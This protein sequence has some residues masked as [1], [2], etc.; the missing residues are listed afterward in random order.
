MVGGLLLLFNCRKCYP[1]DTAAHCLCCLQVRRLGGSGRGSLPSPLPASG[2]CSLCAMCQRLL[3]PWPASSLRN[4]CC[5]MY[6]TPGACYLTVFSKEWIILPK[7]LTYLRLFSPVGIDC[8][9]P[10]FQESGRP[11]SENSWSQWSYIPEPI[12]RAFLLGVGSFL[13]LILKY[14]FEHWGLWNYHISRTV[15]WKE[16][17]C[18]FNN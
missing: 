11:V 2:D 9:P 5:A 18:S 8:F 13:L 10:G 1:K 17:A 15:L 6:P 16:L 4:R 12:L 3:T 14:A 7:W